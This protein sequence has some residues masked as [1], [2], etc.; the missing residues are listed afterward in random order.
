MIYRG[1]APDSSGWPLDAAR[2]GRGPGGTT[3]QQETDVDPKIDLPAIRAAHTAWL[4]D[5]S[6]GTRADLTR[7]NLTEANLTEANLTGANLTGADLTGADLT[8]A[9]APPTD[10]IGWKNVNGRLEKIT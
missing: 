4:T 5:P 10:Q 2:Q 8:M 9:I 6:T 3:P 1:P 7:A